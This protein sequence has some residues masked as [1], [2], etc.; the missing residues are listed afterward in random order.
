MNIGRYYAL[1]LAV[2]AAFL[3]M[4]PGAGHA[5]DAPT[6]MISGQG[7]TGPGGYDLTVSQNGDGTPGYIELLGGITGPVVQ[8][9]P[10]GEGRDCWCLNIKRTDSSPADGDQRA[11][12]YIRDNGD[13]ITAFD[14]I[15]FITSIGGNCNSF[16][17]GRLFF[18]PLVHGD[19]TAVQTADADGDG[20]ADDRDA[21]PDTPSGTI[22]NA[23]GC[24]IE[25][26]VPCSGPAR[27]GRWYNH[28]QYVAAATKAAQ[29]FYAARLITLRERNEIIRAAVRS[30]CGTNPRELWLSRKRLQ[31]QP[32]RGQLGR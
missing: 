4:L 21:C 2:L 31:F 24:G 14:Q 32:H 28:G 5:G 6:P 10:P 27:G 30:D 16:A 26:L 7:S 9:V 25:Q 11:N 1:S 17:T 15:S 13:G 19:F 22:V 20:V 18:I 8:V 3:L 12:V 23:R 29:A